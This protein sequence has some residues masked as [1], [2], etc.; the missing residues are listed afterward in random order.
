MQ[1]L[2]DDLKNNIISFSSLR[3]KTSFTLA[4]ITSSYYRTNKT[5]GQEINNFTISKM[6]GFNRTL[7]TK[8]LIHGYTQ[9][10]KNEILLKM[11][12]GKWRISS[13]STIFIVKI[14]V[15]VKTKILNVIMVN[16]ENLSTPFCY[17]IVADY[18]NFVGQLT[19][20][21]MAKLP[22]EK[23]HVIG[24]SLGAHV[25]GIGAQMQSSKVLRITGL[26][27]AGPMF[28][29]TKEKQ[30]LDKSSALNVDIIHTSMAGVSSPFGHADF[31]VNGGKAQP[32]CSSTDVACSHRRS[33]ELYLE[34][35]TSNVGF[36]AVEC[37][38]IR[39]FENNRCTNNTFTPMGEPWLSRGALRG[40]FYVR[41][42][43]V[44]PYAL[45]ENEKG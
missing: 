1:L 35:I 27:P 31:Y 32:N 37:D 19:G 39:N 8:I 2:L 40:T 41:T 23:T 45:S 4:A 43:P 14:L 12:D 10:Y 3:E 29:N 34:S 13:T 22:P 24:F 25:A 42:N 15:Y 11:K 36:K 21:L 16:W 5:E 6:S 38:S 9:S 26:D 28:L 44:E 20:Y 30:R 17:P 18:T 7:Y 33:M